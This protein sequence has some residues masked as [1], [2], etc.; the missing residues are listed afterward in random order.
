MNRATPSSN[1]SAFAHALKSASV[2]KAALPVHRDAGASWPRLLAVGQVRL[3]PEVLAGGAAARC[4]CL[5]LAAGDAEAASHLKRSAAVGLHFD[6]VLVGPRLRGECDAWAFV[7]R[8][9]SARPWQE[10][11][12]VAAIGEVTPRAERYALSLGAA[13]V[14][15]GESDFERLLELADT[16]RRRRA[17]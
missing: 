16:A 17:V 3:P 9:R 6:L 4:S 7:S 12:L 5:C 13:G 15:D 11:A 14:F 1:A 2:P 10:W 8:L